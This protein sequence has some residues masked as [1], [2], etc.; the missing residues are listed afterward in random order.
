M[1]LKLLKNSWYHVLMLAM[2]VFYLFYSPEL[3]ARFSTKGQPLHTDGSIPTELDQ[4]AFVVEGVEASRREQ[5]V[6]N[7]YGWAFI[8]PREDIHSDALVREIVLISDNRMY[9]F[10]AETV[11]RSPSIPSDLK[12]QGVDL[13]T[14]GFN[15]V[16]LPA[17]IKPGKYRI[18]II[19]RD[20]SV[21]TAY[22]S[23]KPACFLIK[24]PNTM[25]VER[26]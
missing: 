18:G 16:I 14:L 2:M 26:K 4:I 11:S 5:D 3:V 6:W 19:F 22:Y 20:T 23:D 15:T 9:F 8:P 12:D 21:G 1:I 10:S 17:A 24:T 7:L 25:R 13:D